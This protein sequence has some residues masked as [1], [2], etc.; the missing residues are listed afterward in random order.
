MVLEWCS[1]GTLHH[2][3]RTSR[4]A[5]REKA[6]LSVQTQLNMCLQAALGLTHL[7]RYGIHLDGTRLPTARRRGMPRLNPV[8][9]NTLPAQIWV[10]GAFW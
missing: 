10:P 1:R 7:H 6:S 8:W 3:L 5:T 4:A 9:P 2:V